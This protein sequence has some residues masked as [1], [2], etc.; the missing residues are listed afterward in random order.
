MGNNLHKIAFGRGLQLLAKERGITTNLVLRHQEQPKW[1]LGQIL[2]KKCFPNLRNF[3]FEVGNRPEFQERVIEQ[4]ML[5]PGLKLEVQFKD[6]AT[7]TVDYVLENLQQLLNETTSYRINHP[8]NN[9]IHV[10][11]IYSDKLVEHNFLDRFKDDFQQ[12]FA[13]DDEACCAQLPEPDENVFHFRNFKSELTDATDKLG[14]TELGPQQT[15]EE[16]FGGL[17]RG[18]KVAMLSRFKTGDVQQY[19][20]ALEDRGTQVRLISGQTPVQDFCFLKN[21][22]KEVVGSEISTFFVWAAYLGRSKVRSYFVQSNEKAGRTGGYEWQD[23]VLKERYTYQF[24]SDK[25]TQ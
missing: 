1:K 16:L 21:A 15:A 17:S 11:F 8:T 20:Q 23:P 22:K 6:D 12:L 25:T 9:N 4:K 3:D 13:F 18:D 2:I 14:F 5:A 24:Y 10:P 19:V 7:T